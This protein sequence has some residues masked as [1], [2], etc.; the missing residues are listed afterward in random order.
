MNGKP[1]GEGCGGEEGQVQIVEGEPEAREQQGLQGA[2]ATHLVA[3]VTSVSVS[4]TSVQVAMQEG[5]GSETIPAPASFSATGGGGAGE[6]G[7]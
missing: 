2:V 6:S 3:P 1:S 7:V 4:P 5:L